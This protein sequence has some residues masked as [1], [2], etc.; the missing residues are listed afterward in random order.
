MPTNASP[1]AL[2]ITIR[3][4]TPTG[5]RLPTKT[6]LNPVATNSNPTMVGRPNE[7]P[8]AGRQST[9]RTYYWEYRYDKTVNTVR[10]V[11]EIRPEGCA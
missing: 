7:E 6:K 10:G 4:S 9:F 8:V 1:D 3:A 11:S 5:R 2:I